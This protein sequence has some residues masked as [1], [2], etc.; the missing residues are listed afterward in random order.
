[1]KYNVW[2]PNA[3]EF[4]RNQKGLHIN[5]GEGGKLWQLALPFS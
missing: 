2:S 5:K 1:M 4:G 3:V